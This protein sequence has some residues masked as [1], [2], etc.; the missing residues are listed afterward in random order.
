MRENLN[1]G[2]LHTPVPNEGEAVA[3]GKHKPSL[4]VWLEVTGIL[5]AFLAFLG[6]ANFHQIATFMG[7]QPDTAPSTSTSPTPSA[8]QIPQD[9]GPDDPQDAGT[10]T[11]ALSDIHAMESDVPTYS[12]SAMSQFY[13]DKSTTFS[14]LAQAATNLLLKGYLAL[15]QN[16]TLRLE[17]DYMHEA[18]NDPADDYSASDLS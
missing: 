8:P 3:H 11:S 4:V 10:C 12:Y 2:V 9:T 14:S 16:V 1:P 7:G 15:I 13:G 18:L 6:V 5:L 17:I